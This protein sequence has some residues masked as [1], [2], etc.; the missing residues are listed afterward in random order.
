MIGRRLGPYEITAKLGEGGMA[1]VYRATDTKLERQVAIKVLPAAFT[2]DK[3]RLARFGRE[4]KLLAQLHHP[5]IASIFGLEESAGTLALVMELVEGPTL[6]ERLESGSIPLSESLSVARQIAEALE[7]A[8]QKGIIHRDLKPANIKLRSDGTVKVLDF[9]LAKALDPASAAS[10]PGSASQLAASPTLSLSATQMGMIL[11]TAA[12]MAPEQAKGFTVD[13]RAD[14]W[15]FGVVLFEMLT[16]QRLF[17][18]DSVPDTLARVLQCKVD[19]ESLPESTPPAI[20]RLLRRCLERNPTNRLHDIADA[21]I[22]LDDVLG[23]RLEEGVATAVRPSRSFLRHPLLAWTAGAL[24][25]LAVGLL[26]HR[27]QAGS[28]TPREVSYQLQSYDTQAIFAARFMPDGQTTV[29]SAALEGNE[30][31]LF[32]IRPGSPA[33]QPLGLQGVHLLAVSSRGELAVLDHAVYTGHHRLFTGTLARMPLEGG[34]P[35]DLLESVREADWTPDGSELAVIRDV[36]GRDRLEL[37]IGTVLYESS[38]YLSD[39]RVSPGGDRIAF[40]EHPSRFDDRGSVDVVDLDGHAR[41]LS[42]GYWAVEGLAWSPDGARLYFSATKSGSALAIFGVDLEGRAWRALEGAGDLIL[43]DIARDGTWAVTQDDFPTQLSF[44]TAA[45]AQSDLSWLNSGVAPVLSA[46][47]KTLMFTDQSS[48]AGANYSVCLRPTAGGGIVSLGEGAG[49]AFS[50]DGRRVLA[51]VPSTPPRVVSYPVGA[52]QPVRLDPGGFENVSQ[53]W[54]LRGEDRLL[55]GGN[56]P[57]HPPSCFLIDPTAGTMEAVGPEGVRVCAPSPDGKGFLTESPSGWTIFPLSGGGV[58]QPL[59]AITSDDVFVRWSPDG[60]AV[61]FFH[62]AEIPTTVDRIDVATGL[63][64]TALLVA[65][66]DR[67]GLV[68]ILGVALGDNQQ[69]VA[70]ASW[71]Y[72]SKLY[73]VEGAR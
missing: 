34:T 7:E 14:I 31:E 58:P 16:G 33:P 52:G 63:R 2:E 73:R 59:A 50:A 29:V 64:E 55:V 11:G 24:L 47:A 51:V 56:L 6:A 54:W 57:G 13:K 26:A 72:R 28:E 67:A 3:E 40:M 53:A 71:Y 70:Y 32:V 1:E 20:R 49:Q 65:P 48:H 17:E 8:H 60:S 18:G 21:R 66:E 23:G 36:G 15:A 35:R 25:G 41:V 37:P 5:N 42:G 22:V 69:S 12:Y 19:F 61:Y 46:D 62:R 10:G 4:A 43:H 9:G 27:Q 38:G 39:P 45:G 68:S 30:P 44:R